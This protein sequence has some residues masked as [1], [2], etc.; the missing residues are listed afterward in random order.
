MITCP[1]CDGAGEVFWNP[2]RVR[3]PQCEMS[4][5]CRECGGSGQVAWNVH[6]DLDGFWWVRDS[7]GLHGPW[8]T[9]AEALKGMSEEARC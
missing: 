3:D 4:Q 7:A 8:N 2:S 5:I 1:T 9:E 6:A